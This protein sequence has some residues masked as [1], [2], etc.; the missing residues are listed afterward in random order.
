MSNESSPPAEI[1]DNSPLTGIRSDSPA[2]VGKARRTAAIAEG[3]SVLHPFREKRFQP[4]LGKMGVQSVSSP[5]LHWNNCFLKA[6][7]TT[8]HG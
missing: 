6:V 1:H 4:K 3:K 2:A 5:N 7:K 8:W